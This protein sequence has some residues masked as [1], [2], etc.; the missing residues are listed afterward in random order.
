[1]QQ[2]NGVSA[3]I[4][5]D[6]REE[7][8]VIMEDADDILM[9]IAPQAQDQTPDASDEF[10][11]TETEEEGPDFSVEGIRRQIQQRWDHRPDGISHKRWQ[12]MMESFAQRMAARIASEQQ[13][14]SRESAAAGADDTDLEEPADQESPLG[15][16]ED[17]E[18]HQ[19]SELEA[20]GA[21]EPQKSPSEASGF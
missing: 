4:G 18:E 7:C 13:M 2:Q 16:Q 1:M 6:L 14:A 8:D 15:E 20:A 12:E 10:G 9:A 3:A 17:Q 5:Q 11:A 21:G 19:Q